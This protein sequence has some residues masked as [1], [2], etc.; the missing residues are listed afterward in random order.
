MA[1]KFKDSIP[2]SII[3]V[4]GLGIVFISLWAISKG[5]NLQLF[6]VA[7][8]LIAF[9]GLIKTIF[10]AFKRRARKEMTGGGAKE[11]HQAHA[12]HPHQTHK[13]VQTRSHYNNNPQ[14]SPHGHHSARFCPNCG[15]PVHSSHN[16]CS[17]CGAKL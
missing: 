7:G 3:L 12:P 2:G 17:S 14:R 6:I 11:L 15:A 9:Y 16:Y 4:I 1:K 10:E 5:S 13:S 8:G